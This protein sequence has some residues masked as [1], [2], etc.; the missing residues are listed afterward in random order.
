MTDS[1]VSVGAGNPVR[2][3]KLER[4]VIRCGCGDPMSHAALQLPCPTPR[5]TEPL[6]VMYYYRNPVKRLVMGLAHALGGTH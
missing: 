5:A 6:P 4:T 2:S 1:R 3:I